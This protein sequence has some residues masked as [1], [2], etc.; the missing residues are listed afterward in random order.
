MSKINLA[1]FTLL[2]AGTF[3]TACSQLESGSDA[4]GSARTIS[5]KSQKGPFVKGTK[6]T[7]YGMDEKLKQTGT[8][9][10]TEIDN[11]QGEYSLKKIDLDDRYAWLNANGY[12]INE[13]NGERSSQT[14]SLNSLVDLQDLDHV[15]INVLT[16]LAFDRIRY[17]VKQ[18]KTV[19]EA[20]RQ[21]EKEVM[22]AFGFS[23]ETEA[24][25]QLDILGNSEDDAKL[26]AISLIMLT[27]KDMGEVASTMAAISLDLEK[28]GTWDDTV[29]IRR[30][31]D[32]VS[33]DY[34][35]GVFD[36]AKVGLEPVYDYD[37]YYTY[38]NGGHDTTVPNIKEWVK[39]A[40]VPDFKKFLKQFASPWDS[41]WGH[42]STQ[43]EVRRTTNFE[44]KRRVICR[45]GEWRPYAGERD[46]GD[47][48]VDTT[49]K[50]GSFVDER[51]GIVYKTLDIELKNGDTVTWMASLLEYDTQN[52]DDSIPN[53]R[54]KAYAQGMSAYRPGVGR[55]YTTCQIFGYS[56]GEM[57]ESRSSSTVYIRK[58]MNPYESVQGICPDGWHIP[59][60]QE[61]DDMADAI[62]DNLEMRE[63]MRHPQ[64][65]NL[66]QNE[67]YW[68]LFYYNYTIIPSNSYFPNSAYSVY[69]SA[70][71]DYR[72]PSYVED[73]LLFG[74]RC[75]KD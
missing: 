59:N 38:Y 48:P 23:E 54:R 34:H 71:R 12:F 57:C 13:L 10:S 52:G 66:G 31:K 20:K 69:A 72:V 7:L 65:P 4:S 32:L 74:L 35:D 40:E 64:Y 47:P 16:H 3:F 33:M 58:Q 46:E 62:E 50:Y 21:A 75:V 25:D 42:C 8:H 17:L 15:N 55:G 44:E 36:D 73:G 5:G 18:G 27:G 67:V 1:I 53:N 49:G 43:D 68:V 9:F 14:I 28:D 41:V 37:S 56:T 6:V 29:L 45:S 60:N 39:V 19:G 51:D 24:F 70:I 26:L 61:W 30:T 2:V 11:D 22:T 63:L